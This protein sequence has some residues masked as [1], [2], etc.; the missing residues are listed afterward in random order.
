MDSDAGFV[1]NPDDVIATH[2]FSLSQI[3]YAG[4][5]SGGGFLPT[6]GPAFVNFY[7]GPREFEMISGAANERL[8]KGIGPGCA[9]RGRAFLEIAAQPS[10]GSSESR[11]TR[12]VYSS[13][14]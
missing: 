13:F 4:I 2:F 7:G 6:F 3:S 14:L 5:G 12:L 11:S 8:N 1:V 9:Y 10:G